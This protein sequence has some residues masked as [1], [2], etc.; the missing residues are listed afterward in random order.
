MLA[1][2]CVKKLIVAHSLSKIP[3]ALMKLI[4]LDR[5]GVINHDSD[6]YIRSPEQWIA[7]PNSI[8][9][10]ADLCKAGYK[11]ALATNQSGIGRGYYSLQ[12][13]H[14]MHQ[15]MQALVHAAGGEITAIAYCPHTPDEHCKCRKPAPG[16]LLTLLEGHSATDSDIWFV[17]DSLR[18]LEAAW[19][20]N[21]QAALVKTGKGQS[22]LDRGVVPQ[23]TPIF[24]DLAHF[25]RNLLDPSCDFL[26]DT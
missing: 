12:T 15:K 1:T 13:L 25:T 10:I 8:Q 14:A 26:T 7:L 4:I 22:T 23:K 17:G 21:M 18:D 2:G 9:A 3:K 16:M 20:I 11:V 6:N 19:A 24:S 5:D